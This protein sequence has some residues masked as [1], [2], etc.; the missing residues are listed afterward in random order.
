MTS[1]EI[2]KRTLSRKFESLDYDLIENVIYLE[3]QHRARFK[4]YISR[5][6]QRWLAIL[7]IGLATALSGFFAFLAVD[8]LSRLKYSLVIQLSNRQGCIRNDT[9]DTTDHHYARPLTNIENLK[10]MLQPY[11]LLVGW[12]SLFILAG[13]SMVTYLAPVAAGS[14]I[15][16][17]K[18]YLNGVKIP[19]VVRFKTYVT[20]LLGVVSSVVGGLAVGKEGPF[21]QCGAAIGAGLSQGKTTS[22]NLDLN[23]FKAFR[24][25]RDKRDFVSAGASAGVAAAFGAPIGGV[26]F[27][28]EEGASFWNQALTWRLFFCSMTTSFTINLLMCAYNNQGGILAFHSLVNFGLVEELDYFWYEI[29][30]YVCI[31]ICGG[32]IGAS[33]CYL[34]VLI[35]NFRKRHISSSGLKVLE[36]VLVTILTATAGILLILYASECRKLP[37][38]DGDLDFVSGVKHEQTSLRSAVYYKL[39]KLS[40]NDNSFYPNKKSGHNSTSSILTY[41]GDTE[42]KRAISDH[43]LTFMCPPGEYSAMSSLWLKTSEGVASTFMILQ[44]NIWSM[45]TLAIFF[46]VYYCL[47]VIT[48]G[49][50][51][52]AG[53]FIPSLLIGASGG[54]LVGAA[55]LYFFGPQEWLIQQNKFAI[56]G[57]VSVLGGIVRMTISLTVIVIEA[58][59]CISFGMPIMICLMVSKWV[60]DSFIEGLYDLA[61]KMANIPFL[62]W[63]PPLKSH[64][65]YASDIMEPNVK[66]LQTTETVSNIISIL[67][68]TTHNGFP[69]VDIDNFDRTSVMENSDQYYVTPASRKSRIPSTSDDD[70]MSCRALKVSGDSSQVRDHLQHDAI[71]QGHSSDEFLT[72]SFQ[73]CSVSA[74]RESQGRFR[75]L[76]LRWQLLVMLELKIFNENERSYEKLNLEAFQK[77]Y[78]NYPDLDQVVAGLTEEMYRFHV[79]LRSIM[80]PTPYI[81]H[82]SSSFPRIFQIFRSLGLRHLVVIDDRNQVVG[83]ITRKDLA[84]YVRERD[85]DGLF[86]FYE[87][88]Y[89]S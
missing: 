4:N 28:L 12:N 69:V 23:F 16:V 80:N 72:G 46:V 82:H 74:K 21:I 86:R 53:V 7:L 13:A 54:R 43:V 83:M 19:Q 22:F 34:H 18:C 47:A 48:Y 71:Y 5:E 57:A 52:S 61:I 1:H 62:E 15:P 79:D 2:N 89:S 6:L 60:A 59:G 50:S 51:V 3:H 81:V 42:I 45:K 67:K 30:I 20:K 25:D 85:N 49:L 33:F 27:A 40:S 9:A 39:F 26:L 84:R 65:I 37:Q 76:I 36:A 70:P 38:D 11:A 88:D 32:L 58:T 63:E 56:V 87:L 73:R 35:T 24:N 66:V 14:G 17:V 29:P 31:A 75:G 8:Y 44:E 64:T 78:P 68:S 10:C 77:S 55:L 41:D